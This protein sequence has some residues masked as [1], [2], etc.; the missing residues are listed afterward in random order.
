MLLR[1][2]AQLIAF[3]S[4][5]ALA[6]QVSAPVHGAA[7]TPTFSKDVAPI[8]Y[9]RCV[10]C[11]R[12]K[13]MAPMSLMTFDE[14]RP[15]A[16]AIKQKV[17]AREMP[18]WGADPTIGKFANDISLTNDEIATIAAWVDGGGAEGSKADL[19]RAP[20]FYEGW[21]IGKPDYVFKMPVPVTVPADGALPYTFVTIPTNL[22]QDIWIRGVELKPSDRRVVHHIVSHL[23]SGTPTDL[24]PKP[25]RDPAL[26]EIGSVGS[27]VPG[28]LYDLFDPGVAR[29]IPA[30]SS[31]VLQMHYTTIGQP[32]VDQT[33]VGVLLASGPPSSLKQIRGGQTSN[34]TFVIP[35]GSP[36]FE[37]VA[38]T[39]MQSNT[40]LS[41]LLPHMHARGKDVTF[42][43]VYP[44]GK[45]ELLLRIPKYDFNW[46]I[47]YKL[48]EPKPLPRGTTLEVIAHFDNSPANRFN[49]DPTAE[50]RWGDQTWEEMLVGYY[51]TVD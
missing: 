4:A 50:V 3:G 14:A 26:T 22:K 15:W 28:Q 48:A 32:I 44:D 12:A 42:K 7:A 21:S 6:A 19:P 11:H 41:V 23:V 13:G 43:A 46:Q 45:E 35:P 29:K 25:M 33:E 34:T 16:R 8:F 39:V 17:V 5:L 40:H 18:P 47:S 51:N 2:A 38:K 49:P 20:V 10:E 1:R 30:G 36:S 37:V 24:A 9:K 27:M 31:I